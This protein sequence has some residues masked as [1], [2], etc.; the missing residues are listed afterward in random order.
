MGK[1]AKFFLGTPRRFLTTG[2]VVISGMTVV[3]F[4]PGAVYKA[5]DRL[6]VECWPLIEICLVGAIVLGGLRMIVAGGKKGGG[7][8]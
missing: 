3:H 6:V 5:A 2:I 4:W 7:S 1:F 8:K